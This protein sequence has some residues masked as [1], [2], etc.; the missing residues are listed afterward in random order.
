MHLLHLL[1]D[2]ASC[3]S[4]ARAPVPFLALSLV[5]VPALVP[6]LS[7]FL[8]PSPVPFHDLCSFLYIKDCKNLSV[9]FVFSFRNQEKGGQY[10]IWTNTQTHKPE[11]SI[12]FLQN[13]KLLTQARKTQNIILAPNSELHSKL[14][15]NAYQHLRKQTKKS[16]IRKILR[17]DEHDTR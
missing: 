14:D 11:F 12:W 5:H 16:W 7:L 6:V 8:F 2:L 17:A 3:P 13:C 9:S 15:V 10:I 4:L 1:L